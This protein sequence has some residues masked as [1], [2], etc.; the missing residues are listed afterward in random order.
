MCRKNVPFI[1]LVVLL[2]SCVLQLA[3]GKTLRNGSVPIDEEDFLYDLFPPGF[4]W[5]FATA[6]YQIEGGWNSDGKG[7]NIWDNWTHSE[8]SPIFD[9]TSG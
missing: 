1:L 2:P 8:P 5:G 3:Q 9:G 7:P 4:K 6:A